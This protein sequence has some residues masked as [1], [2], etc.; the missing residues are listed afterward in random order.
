MNDNTPN[1]QDLTSS[2]TTN[3]SP[4]DAKE[5]RKFRIRIV[6]PTTHPLP[7]T[8]SNIEQHLKIIKAYF[9]AT[10]EGKK[11]VMYKD[12]EH[13]GLDF[14]H[15]YVSA[16]N[17]FLQDLG[18]IEQS[19]SHGMYIPTKNAIEFQRYTDWG[20]KEKALD[21]LRD[22]VKN[23]W[24]WESVKQV[25]LIQENGT[26]EN[27]LLNKL[28][29]DSKANRDKH[30]GSL[31]ILISYLEYVGL[32]KRDEKTNKIKMA[33]ELMP[34]EPSP[35]RLVN[36]EKGFESQIIETNQKPLVASQLVLTA[37]NIP[38]KEPDHY[39]EEP[40]HFTLRVKLDEISIQLLE[41]EIKYIKGKHALLLKTKKADEEAKT[42]S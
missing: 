11:A 3:G 12:F 31:K 4:P 33:L 24:F 17:K 28:G 30:I 38:S 21:I 22:L 41:E 34:K 7:H 32:V 23:S 36:E 40:G 29:A 15:T 37:Q 16:N 6:T 25:L 26:E 13:S 35:T 1:E 10:N 9:I 18:L 19:G 39:R 27:D 14:H 5:G 8:G 42:I 2:Q 20:Q